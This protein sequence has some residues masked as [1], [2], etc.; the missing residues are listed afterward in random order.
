MKEQTEMDI[1]FTLQKIKQRKRKL[2]PKTVTA[3]INYWILELDGD[4]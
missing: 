2:D 4:H 1:S 3:Q